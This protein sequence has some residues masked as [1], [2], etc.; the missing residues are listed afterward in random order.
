ML[1]L[2]LSVL[3][4][5]LGLFQAYMVNQIPAIHLSNIQKRRFFFVLFFAT[6]LL[7]VL[8]NLT[9]N[10]LLI[11]IE[12]GSSEENMTPVAQNGHSI[13]S[14][15]NPQAPTFPDN[16]EAI[17]LPEV[18]LNSQA[19]ELLTNN[20]AEQQTNPVAATPED[21]VADNS[22]PHIREETSEVPKRLS[23]KETIEH[24]LTKIED[25]TAK[26]PGKIQR[27]A[28]GAS[29][30][31]TGWT[32]AASRVAQERHPDF[33]SEMQEIQASWERGA[34]IG[35]PVGVVLGWIIIAVLFIFL[36]ILPICFFCMMWWTA[37]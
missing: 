32:E 24:I 35:S 9:L 31:T 4:G 28:Q 7:T 8:L 34:R 5:L 11:G 26:A 19:E 15:D 29:Q 18:P 2:L 36:G 17:P 21:E 1:S 33:M 20:Q 27:L 30:Q 37:R 23:K 12:S 14:I 3:M 16:T 10:R 13:P 22:L 6:L 25:G